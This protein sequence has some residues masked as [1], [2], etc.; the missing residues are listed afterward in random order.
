M[1]V[2]VLLV[3]IFGCL[4]TLVGMAMYVVGDG[5]LMAAV[6]AR[7]P[8]AEAAPQESKDYSDVFFPYYTKCEGSLDHY[9]AIREKA[10][11][12]A[13]TIVNHTPDSYKR[14]TSIRLLREAVIVASASIDCRQ[15]QDTENGP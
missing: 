6:Y 12:L 15:A 1:M 4:G 13:Q 9:T 5:D 10:R 8:Q 14:M 2:K 3:G 11:E 7:T